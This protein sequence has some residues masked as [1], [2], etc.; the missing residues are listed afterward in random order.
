MRTNLAIR[1]QAE[2]ITNKGK[3]LYY[4]LGADVLEI[5]AGTLNWIS[6]IKT[7]IGTVN[8]G[9]HFNWV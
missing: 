9:S 7:G 3:L 6:F 4:K 5:G 2:E 8:L 1:N